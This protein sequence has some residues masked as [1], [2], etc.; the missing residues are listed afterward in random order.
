[1]NTPKELKYTKEH[2]WVRLDGEFAVV[3]ITDF[4]QSELGDIVF[5]DIQTQGETLGAGEVFG[6]IEAVKTVADAMM[7]VSGEVI[8]V[9]GELEG[10]PE[11]VNNDP[12]GKGW[13]VKIKITDPSDI[14]SLLDATQYEAICK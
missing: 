12:Y 2:E 8:E 10:A 1:M 5:V 13:M 14:D 6:T 9:N 3:G 7:P 4:A 11:L